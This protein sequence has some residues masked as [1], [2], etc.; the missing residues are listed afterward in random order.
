MTRFMCETIASKLEKSWQPIIISSGIKCARKDRTIASKRHAELDIPTS[1]EAKKLLCESFHH[2]GVLNHMDSKVDLK[3]GSQD[4]KS[5]MTS[6]LFPPPPRI[7]FLPRTLPPLYRRCCCTSLSPGLPVLVVM[8]DCVRCLLVPP[9]ASEISIGTPVAAA[10]LTT[11]TCW[12]E[13]TLWLEYK[14]ERCAATK[15]P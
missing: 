3:N 14:G 13:Q 6:R 11:C 8:Y 10:Q 7:S 1:K 15:Q 5:E 4:P 12:E 2:Q 9:L